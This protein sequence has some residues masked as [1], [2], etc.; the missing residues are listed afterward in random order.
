MRAKSEGRVK[1]L[2]GDAT[3]SF[4]AGTL[5]DVLL[6]LEEDEPCLWDDE[7]EAL[8]LE[9]VVFVSLAS[10]SDTLDVFGDGNDKPLLA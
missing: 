3:L 1:L 7:E 2:T 6:P 9:E 5:D 10:V 8:G 4:F